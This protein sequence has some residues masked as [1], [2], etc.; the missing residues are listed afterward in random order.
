MFKNIN[1]TVIIL[2]VKL[3]YGSFRKKIAYFSNFKKLPIKSCQL[4]Y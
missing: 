2:I 3:D 1:L 4:S